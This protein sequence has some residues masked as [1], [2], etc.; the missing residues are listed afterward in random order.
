MINT[1]RNLREIVDKAYP[2]LILINDK[3]ASVKENNLKWSKKEILGHLIDSAGNNQQKFV[4]LIEQNNIE[5]TGYHQDFWVS[6]QYY[7]LSNWKNLIELWMG[8]NIHI[9]HIIEYVPMNKLANIINLNGSGSFTLEFIM[10]DYV[11]HLKHHLKQILP[12][13]G[14]ESRFENIYNS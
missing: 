1:A 2:H 4:R 3:A 6:S 10:K 12:N 9:A 7:N 13:A 5:F 11:E 8:F 14:I